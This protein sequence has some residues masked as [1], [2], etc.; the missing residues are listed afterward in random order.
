MPIDFN[1]KKLERWLVTLALCVA[2]QVLPLTAQTLTSA[3]PPG[4]PLAAKAAGIDG[5]VI[6]KGTISKEGK[7]QDIHVL[8]GPPEL[9]QAAIDAVS[10]WT[11]KP[12]KHFGQIVEVVTTVTVNFNM[13]VGEQK[14]AAQAKAQAELAKSSQSLTSPDVPQS[15]T[16]K[17]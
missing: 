2:A 16:P 6:L 1:Q 4:Y 15:P 13:G 7:M 10:G 8:S 5:P 3:K 11:Y 12:Y 17:P 9:R 14:T